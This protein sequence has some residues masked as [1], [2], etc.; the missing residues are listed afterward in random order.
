[1]TL[2]KRQLLEDADS[3]EPMT[4]TPP[5]SDGETIAQK[6]KHNM[7]FSNVL[8]HGKIDRLEANRRALVSVTK[9]RFADAEVSEQAWAENIDQL[10]DAISRKVYQELPTAAKQKKDEQRAEAKHKD[11]P[12]AKNK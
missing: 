2:N 6:L 1:M 11:Q 9:R 4:D 12:Q 10:V 3:S 8:H 7:A 5:N